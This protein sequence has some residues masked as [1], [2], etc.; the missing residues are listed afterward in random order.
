[1]FFQ[2][3]M[4]NYMAIFTPGP[5][6]V[7]SDSATQVIKILSRSATPFLTIH[8]FLGG[9]GVHCGERLSQAND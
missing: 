2:T 6:S 9:S 7:H 3:V 4:Q 5:G 8:F 1:M